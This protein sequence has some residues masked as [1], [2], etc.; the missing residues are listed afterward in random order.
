ME[1][2]RWSARAVAVS[3]RVAP[4]R[5]LLVDPAFALSAGPDFLLA[6]RRGCRI[7]SDDT[8]AANVLYAS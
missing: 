2:C 3:G 1:R 5:I 4:S 8:N 7:D 6:W